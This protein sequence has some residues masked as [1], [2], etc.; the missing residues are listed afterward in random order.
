MHVG[1]AVC[2]FFLF[3]VSVGFVP[4]ASAH[5]MSYRCGP[6]AVSI[7]NGV[8]HYATVFCWN[9]NCVGAFNRFPR[10]AGGVLTCGFESL[11]KTVAPFWLKFLASV[12][13]LVVSVGAPLVRSSWP[14]FGDQ[15]G[16]LLPQCGGVSAV[17]SQRLLPSSSVGFLC[18]D[19]FVQVLPLCLVAPS[20]WRGATASSALVSRDETC[21]DRLSW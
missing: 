17:G 12:V 2:R 16:W 19:S 13:L 4:R 7:L 3:W 21:G 11:R 10:P 1:T 6:W 8:A 5:F 18:A 9:L 15:R 20:G 14:R